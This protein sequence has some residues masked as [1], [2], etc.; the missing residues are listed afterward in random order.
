MRPWLA[1]SALLGLLLLAGVG[2]WSSST[3][4]ADGQAHA[5][6]ATLRCPTCVAESVADSTSPM[7]SGMRAII[8]EQ[9]AEGRS[10]DQVRD[11]FEQRYGSSVLLEPPLRGLGWVLWAIPAAAVPFAAWF[12]LRD[13]AGRPA[14]AMWSVI[15]VAGAAG[16]AML[17]LTGSGGDTEPVSAE[18]EAH[19]IEVLEEAVRAEP[20]VVAL[21]T[22]L[23]RAL[24]ENGRLDEAVE[25]Y[26]A[27]TRLA[28]QEP[29]TL[30]LAA[31]ALVR[32]DRQTQAEP[33]LEQALSAAPEHAEALLLLASIRPD[34]DPGARDLMERFL[35]VAP[36]HP[37]AVE[38]E[39]RV[40]AEEDR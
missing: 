23:A 21:R 22:A 13:R 31:F 8:E 14:R 9:L 4:S 33:L 30:Y 32:E 24:D 20:G 34:D 12:V 39:R 15:A 36:D 18:V 11:W 25:Q 16:A 40:R 26:L 28:P 7:A 38:V 27:A 29:S 35:D 19:P 17:A 37:A 5:V 10:P 2:L 3:V 1:R 6:A